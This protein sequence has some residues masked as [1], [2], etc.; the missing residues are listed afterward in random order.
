MRF[1]LIPSL[2]SQIGHSLTRHVHMTGTHF[3]GGMPPCPLAM[4]PKELW[5]L[6]KGS[7]VAGVRGAFPTRDQ[8]A[9]QMKAKDF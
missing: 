4:L 7:G 1:L 6:E 8:G 5:L 3:K 2:S 9:Q